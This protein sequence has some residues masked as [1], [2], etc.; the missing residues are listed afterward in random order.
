MREF[1]PWMNAEKDAH[2]ADYIET[3][4]QNCGPKPLLNKITNPSAAHPVVWQ[5]MQ[6][7]VGNV[8]QLLTQSYGHCLA[9][10][11]PTMNNEFETRFTQTDALMRDYS[12]SAIQAYHAWQA[13][14]PQFQT[15]TKDKAATTPIK[16]ETPPHLPCGAICQAVKKADELAWMAFREDFLADRYIQL[17][18]LAK[19]ASAATTTTAGQDGEPLHCL[20]H[21]GEM[22]ATTDHLNSNIFFQLATSDAVDELVMDSNMMLVGAPGSPAIVGL[23]VSLGMGYARQHG[24]TIHYELATERVLPC[25]GNGQIVSSKAL[26]H[27]DRG[28]TLLIRSGVWHALQSGVQ[29]LGVTNL[30][31]PQEAKKMLPMESKDGEMQMFTAEPFAPTAVIFVPYRVFYAYSFAVAGVSCDLDPVPCWDKSFTRMEYFGLATLAKGEDKKAAMCPV[32]VP[33]AT[34]LAAWEDLRQ[35][36]K[37][38]AVVGDVHE[39]QAVAATAKERVL[40]RFPCVMEKTNW[41]IWQGQEIRQAFEAIHRRYPFT[42]KLSKGLC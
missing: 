17:C 13:V 21:M 34:V 20:L 38:V 24:K 42:E 7:Y 11:S 26:D 9:S 23:M 1:P 30:C 4:S 41:H 2:Y 8:T 5:L 36:H 29:S 25:N 22:L 10:V 32:D 40:I 28:A 27:P 18:R 12:P 3:T 16:Y 37:H 14:Q 31:K 19:Q 33:Q 39:L 35:R 15:A 6:S